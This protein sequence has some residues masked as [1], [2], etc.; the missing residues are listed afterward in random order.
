MLRPRRR[1]TKRLP[2][3]RWHRYLAWSLAALAFGGLLL[4]HGW[5]GLQEESPTAQWPRVSGSITADVG[6]RAVTSNVEYHYSVQ[7]RDYA[8]RGVVDSG[9]HLQRG[10]AVAVLYD[11]DHPEVSVLEVDAG[12]NVLP[13]SELLAGLV[14][15][16]FA[17][18]FLVWSLLKQGRAFAALIWVVQAASLC[19]GVA[20][21][22]AWSPP[23]FFVLPLLGACACIAVMLLVRICP[24]CMGLIRT[25]HLVRNP[26]R[27]P[28]CGVLLERPQRPLAS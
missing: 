7:G 8:G 16:S 20:A 24:V 6:S 5:S 14:P 27:C 3:P 2:P 18:P 21:G 12:R 13:A 4:A 17:V 9:R 26:E 11:P 28:R 25:D 15:V 22:I 1:K 10:Q 23:L 19:V